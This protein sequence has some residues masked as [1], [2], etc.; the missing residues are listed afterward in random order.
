MIRTSVREAQ[1]TVVWMRAFDFSR[2][3]GGLHGV[4]Y[5]QRNISDVC[6]FGLFTKRRVS[7]KDG[8]LVK[9]RAQPNRGPQV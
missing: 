2:Y 4:A 3:A 1:E 8:S 9:V 6:D 5:T 7:Y